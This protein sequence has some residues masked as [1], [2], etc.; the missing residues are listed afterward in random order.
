[1]RKVY[2]AHAMTNRDSVAPMDA[3]VVWLKQHRCR[4]TH[5]KYALF[6]EEL[7]LATLE[8]IRASDVL[9]A[10]VSTYSHGVGFELGY[11]YALGK[12]AIVVAHASAGSPVSEFI[13]GL[14]PELVYYQH[15]TD[16]IARIGERL[17]IAFEKPGR[18]H[19]DLSI[20]AGAAISYSSS[21]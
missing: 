7:A 13:K 4:V 16:L 14:Y 20:F 1:M 10:D 12:K 11:A 17:G 5:P 6:R 9:V 18:T 19:D 3:L 15:A 8:A 2:L 21:R